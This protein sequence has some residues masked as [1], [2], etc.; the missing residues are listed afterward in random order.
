M[1]N[2]KTRLR[3]VSL[4]SLILLAWATTAA[5]AQITPLGDAYT[6]S[7][8]P[9][10]NYGSKTLLDVDGTTQITYI[11]FNLASIP[12]TASV[13]QATLK[14]YVNAVTKA[15]SFNV[16]YVNGAWAESTIDASNAPAL[17][18]TIASDV[19]LT[20]ADK[21]QYILINV[22]AAV[23][24][25]LSGSETNNGLALVA[26]STFN[27]TFD[28][29]ESTTTSHPAELDIAFAG[30]DGTITGVT[31]ASGSG[32]TGG[33]TSGTL[34]LSLTGA[35]A[36]NQVLQWNG[37]A[38][39]CAAVGTG[40]I[41]GVTAGTDLTGGGTSGNVTLNVNTTALNSV[42]PQLAAN[43]T[44]GGTQTI[45]NATTITGTNS[46]GVLQVT[47]TG[48]SGGNPGIVGTTN[49]SSASG[50]KGV[51]SATSG[52]TNGVYGTSSS[53]SGIGV[54]GAS[55][56]VGVYGQASGASQTGFVLGGLV[57]VWGDTG[58][59]AGEYTA[60]LGT[61]DENDAARFYNNG[62]DYITIYAQNNAASNKDALVLVAAGAVF[63]GTCSMDVSGDLACSGTKSAVVPVDGGSR[64]V[65][66]YAIEGPEN[67]F[68][69]AGSGQLSNG[70]VVVKL[71]PVFGQTVNTETEYHVF[72]TPKGDCEGLYVSNETPS[73]FEVH[74]L[75][76][77]RSSI[78]FDYRI[79]AKRKG[80]ESIRLADKTNQYGKE[81]L[82]RQKMRRPVRPTA[83]PQSVPATPAP[84]LRATAQPVAAPPK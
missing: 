9:T 3:F 35:C 67:W 61:A 73:G 22:T 2:L 40:T 19:A 43:N 50:V 82:E 42:Y 81:A 8:D 11:Q 51:A 52:A 64:N 34:N 80:Y 56:N 84:Q 33:G 66:L 70:A 62:S 21:N 4:L 41:T 1:K 68:E 47:N 20:T 7:A 31:T 29:K 38:W 49:S 65:A 55:P 37:S 14:L 46:G 6:N 27:A 44:F 75:R 53:T 24:A 17:G 26:N 30:G 79:M 63:G 32:L 25:W 78:A 60:I 45:N 74:E 12:A 15:G 57:G 59:T 28:S 69:D 5:Y 10:T 13:S 71:E 72:L 83:A 58:G 36:A 18:T 54:Q 39:A 48:T 77:G 23:Q 76:G 16:D